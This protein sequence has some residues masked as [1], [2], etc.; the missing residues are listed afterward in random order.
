MKCL[1]PRLASDKRGVVAPVVALSLFALIAVGGLAFDYAHMA[2]LDTELQQAADQAA[3]AAAT[4]LDGKANAIARATAAAQNLVVNNTRFAN[5]IPS[6]AVTIPTL[7]F[8][9]SYDQPTDSF[10]P[11]T[12]AGSST[13]DKSAKV[14]RVA[15][16][17]RTAYFALTPIVAWLSARANNSG[18]MTAEAVASVGNAICKTPPV[19]ICNP[20]EPKLNGNENLAF[21]ATKGVGLRLV[22]G[23]ATAAG[24]FGWLE[25]GL[26]SGSKTLGEALGYNSPPGDCLPADGVTSKTGMSTSVLN[27]FNTRFDVYANGST[28]CPGIGVCSPAVNTRKDLVCNPDNTN[29]AC[30]GGSWIDAF[31]PYYPA[32]V[33]VLPSDGSTD[34]SI[35]GYPKDLCQ[36]VPSSAIASS[37]AIR[38]TGTWDRDAYFRVNYRY[39]NEAAWRA[40]MGL[41]SAAPLPSR[42]EVY[43]WELTH[44]TVNVSGTNRGIAV[45]QRDVGS[46][47]FA[48]SY[49]AMGEPG[50][51]ASATQADRRRMSVAVLNC[52]ALNAHGKIKNAP[53]VTWLDI[54]LVEPAVDR[55]AKG[56]GKS[57]FTGQKNVY[58]E[59]IGVTASSSGNAGQVLRRDKPYLI[60]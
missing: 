60:R 48:F 45:P 23:D 13:A 4:Q 50:V 14:V 25:S 59:I 38:G 55:P 34:P 32:T 19:M 16:G 12:A 9:D 3:L 26:T 10:G 54:F 24:N 6:R 2:A 40:A 7:T 56:S 30:N 33:S 44:K 51:A 15:V 43:Q 20:D 36:A 42:F 58:V 39:P 8:Y 31:K 57:S 5:D 41:S 53:V 49:P 37:C 27:A 47:N 11:V 52:V 17:G 21:A 29:T 28:T 46:S 35:M 18:I 22:T 1:S